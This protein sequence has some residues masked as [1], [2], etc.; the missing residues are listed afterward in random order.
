M[1][2]ELIFAVVTAVVTGMLGAITGKSKIPNKYIPIQNIII[3]CIAALLA[4]YFEL[5]ND[6]PTAIIVSLG[7]A[8]GV[9]GAYDAARIPSKD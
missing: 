2:F 1:S 3:G 5:F 4:V 8:L 6:I 9:G 7:I